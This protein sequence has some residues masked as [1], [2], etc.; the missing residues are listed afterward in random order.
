VKITEIL[1]HKNP[2][3]L[4]GQSPFGYKTFRTAE[5]FPF[6]EKNGKIFVEFLI[7]AA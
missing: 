2:V 4:A 7:R 3:F 1:T 5:K 6:R